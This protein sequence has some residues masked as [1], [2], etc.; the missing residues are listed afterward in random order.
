MIFCI[1]KLFKEQLKELKVESKNPIASWDFIVN[2]NKEEIQKISLMSSKENISTL[3]RKIA[4]GTSGSFTISIDATLAE[5]DIKYH[6]KSIDET[7]SPQNLKFIFEE[8][9]YDSF[10]SMEEDLTGTITSSEED[11][12]RTFEIKWEW[13]YETGTTKEEIMQ[14][15]L[16][17]TE[18]MRNIR[19][20]DFTIC[21]SGEQINYR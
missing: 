16:K 3:D 11:K 19:N 10:K 5:V 2:N 8:K 15:D 9:E 4:P 14:N 1:S 6:I 20:Y 18:D 12:T 13:K 7:N 21:V 17:D